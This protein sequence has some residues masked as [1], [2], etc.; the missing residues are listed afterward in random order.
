MIDEARCLELKLPIPGRHPTKIGYVLFCLLAGYKINTRVCLYIGVNHLN[1]IISTL[2]GKG[3]PI[4]VDYGKVWCPRFKTVPIHPV[5][6]A[7]MT[8]EQRKQYA[9]IKKPAK[10]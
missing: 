7:Y 8:P 4:T 3:I 5:D 6:I 9:D 2:R 1:S 10:A